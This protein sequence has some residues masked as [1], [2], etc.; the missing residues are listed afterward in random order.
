MAELASA[1]ARARTLRP[2]LVVKLVSTD[3]PHKT[4]AGAVT[5]GVDAPEGVGPAIDRMLSSARLHAP[6]ARLD[7][8]SFRNS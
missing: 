6:Q 2:P 3:L 4:E 5:L 7:G 8:I 1:I